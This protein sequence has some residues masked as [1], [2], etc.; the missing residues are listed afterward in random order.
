MDQKFSC[1]QE[2]DFYYSLVRKHR[3]AILD[4]ERYIWAHPE[5]GFKEWNTSRY[6]AGIFE[7]AGFTVH[8]ADNI[9]GF[10]ADLD[11]GRPGPRILILGEMDALLLPDHPDAVNGCAH[12]CGHNAQCAALVGTALAL[13]EPGALDGLCGSIRLMA[14]PAEEAIEVEF[15]EDLRRQGTIHALS[16][17]VEF[18]YR[19]YMDGCDIAYLL[20]ATP[21]RDTDLDCYDSNGFITKEIIYSGLASHAGGSPHAGINAL[22]AAALGLQAINSIRETFVDSEHVRVHPVITR[23]GDSI[24]IIPAD[25]RLSTYVRGASIES[26]QKNNQRIDRALAGAAASLGAKVRIQDRPGAA[27]LHNDPGLVRL[28]GDIGSSLLGPERVNMHRPWGTGSTD[29][30]DLSC[31]MRTI[32][33]HISGAAGHLHGQDFQIAEPELT[34]VTGAGLQVLLAVELLKDQAQKAKEVMAGPPL[35]YASKEAYFSDMDRFIRD[36][37]MVAYEG[38]H[39]HIQL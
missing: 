14:V 29:M 23:G 39:I 31:V 37:D 7:E 19:G 28:L 17:K 25:V 27:P 8:K 22:Y 36:K 33:P 1:P 6:L 3:Q 9:P 32:H 26:I 24:N 34:C 13:K 20:H 2:Y 35:R 16:G 11:T 21:A 5:T 30:G 12:A 10:Y 38:D 4:A 18:L 15:R